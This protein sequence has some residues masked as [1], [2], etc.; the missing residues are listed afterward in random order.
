MSER[1]SIFTRGFVIV[2]LTATNVGQVAGRHWAGA[3]VVG[4]GISFVWWMNSRS[5][6]R[7]DLRF[8]RECYALGAAS[9]TIFGMWLVKV[10][11]G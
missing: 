4:F 10:I 6:A 7:S 5:A 11:Y 2:T 8:A 9:G 1:L 3:F